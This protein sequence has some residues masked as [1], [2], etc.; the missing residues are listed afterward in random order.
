MRN[1][2]VIIILF[3]LP[4]TVFAEELPVACQEFP[5]TT[6]WMTKGV[7]SDPVLKSSP[8]CFKDGVP[9]EYQAAAVEPA[10]REAADGK[11]GPV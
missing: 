5:P 2:V 9:S 6:T 11:R 3:V 10:Y 4:F 7:S 8:K 1:L